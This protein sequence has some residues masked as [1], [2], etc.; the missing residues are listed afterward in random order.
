MTFK[1]VPASPEELARRGVKPAAGAQPPAP[2]PAPQPAPAAR[3]RAR[4]SRG[5]FA[6]DNPAT[7][8]V[9]E[10]WAADAQSEE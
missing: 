4:A 9:N 1:F 8:G 5:Q 10:A 2:Q 7:P 6:G 3:R